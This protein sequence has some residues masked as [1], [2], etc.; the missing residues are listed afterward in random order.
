MSISANIMDFGAIIGEAG[1]ANAAVND[2]AFAAALAAPQKQIVIP[3]GIFEISQNIAITSNAKQLIGVDGSDVFATISEGT[4]LRWRGATGGTMATLGPAG[5]GPDLIAPAL[6]GI[7]FD[8]RNVAAN[9][10]VVKA[11]RRP[12]LRD[13]QTINV[14][15]IGFYLA[16]GPVGSTDVNCTYRG[17]FQNLSV[18][19]GGSAIGI[20]LDGV[21]GKN[22]CFCDIKGAHVTHKNGIA[23][24]IRAADDNHFYNIAT[25]RVA[26]GMGMTMLIDGL[27]SYVVGNAIWG[28]Q[29]GVTDGT[30]SIYSRGS[31]ARQNWIR[32]LSGVDSQP[33]ITIDQGSELLYD[34]VGG[35]YTPTLAAEKALS[36]MPKRQELTY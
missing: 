1:G 16:S 7:Q 3:E 29:C 5:A 4:V 33:T 23:Y 27:N 13:V 11:S 14:T 32:F 22:A 26:G 17:D 25:S 20:M 36:R 18:S 35:G 12:K 15:G 21:G 19:V 6:S 31:K 8:G 28:M 2:A 9:G 30:A 24:Y 34:F 10:V